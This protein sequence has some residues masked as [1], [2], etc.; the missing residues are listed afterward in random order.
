MKTIHSYFL[1]LV[2][3]FFSLTACQNEQQHAQ[4]E[5]TKQETLI[6]D[7]SDPE[8]AEQLIQQYLAYASTYPEDGE[9][10]ARY[11]YRVAALQY[12]LNNF[13]AARSNLEKAIHKY[14]DHENTPKAVLLLGDI[15]QE[16]LHNKFASSVLYQSAAESMPSLAEEAE[17]AA[18][19]KT[20]F[21]PVTQRLEL[22]ADNMYR[23]STGRVDL[24]LANDYITGT[25]VYAL[26]SPEAERVPEFLYKAG[27]T[28]RTIQAFGKAIELYDWL[29]ERYPGYEKTPQAMFL[30][31]FTLDNDLHRLDEARAVYEEFLAKYPNDE[32][33]DDTQF[34][35][36]NLGKSDEEII[37]SFGAQQ[38]EQ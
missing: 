23:D 38:A 6:E 10:S 25:S 20:G 7:E 35:L 22:I 28:A 21:G 32:F 5:I 11:L 1:V 37:S 26:I 17:V 24:R 8:A 9:A 15:Y 16:K 12:R 14:Y 30:K 3:L 4:S 13:D 29:L 19:N 18:M 27:E 31:A 2:I 33:A 34:L 36:E